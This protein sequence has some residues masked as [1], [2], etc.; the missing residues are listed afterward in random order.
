MGNTCC[1][2]T[3]IQADNSYVVNIKIIS[4]YD[5]ENYEACSRQIKRIVSKHYPL[6][7]FDEI[8]TEGGDK[9]VHVLVNNKTEIPVKF[10][11]WKLQNENEFITAV[12]N[13]VETQ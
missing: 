9:K 8:R 4:P 2:E 12:K 1:H 7:V 13:A 5:E 6:T 10:R 11:F 3:K